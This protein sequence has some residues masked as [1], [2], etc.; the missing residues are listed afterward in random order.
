M[1]TQLGWEYEESAAPADTP[2]QQRGGGGLRSRVAVSR[3]VWSETINGEQ[4]CALCRSRR[5]AIT[6]PAMAAC[7][8]LAS[9][10]VFRRCASATYFPLASGCV[11]RRC[12][13][14]TMTRRDSLKRAP[15]GRGLRQPI[16]KAFPRSLRKSAG[17]RRGGAHQ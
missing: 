6:D 10:C 8:P 9:G 14:A 7:F 2:T 5:E 17:R 3:R 4:P 1:T 11:F 16:R 15:G 12:A 13:S